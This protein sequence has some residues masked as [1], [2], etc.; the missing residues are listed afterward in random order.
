MHSFP[1]QLL[2]FFLYARSVCLFLIL[3]PK[4]FQSKLP[5][6]DSDSS[7]RLVK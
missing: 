3:P 2:I 1:D 7:P 6:K 4:V 5:L